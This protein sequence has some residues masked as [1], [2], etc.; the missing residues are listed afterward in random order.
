MHVDDI[1]DPHNSLNISLK[2]YIFPAII[3]AKVK[4][5]FLSSSEDLCTLCS[6]ECVQDHMAKLK[7]PFLI[8]RLSEI[9]K[10]GLYD[11][12]DEKFGLT[13]KKKEVSSSI[14]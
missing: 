13:E 10:L 7:Y 9:N 4:N 5:P 14:G 11:L 6:V 12:F 8:Y 2:Q 3:F 1:I